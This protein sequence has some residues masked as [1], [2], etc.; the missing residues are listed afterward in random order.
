MPADSDRFYE[1]SQLSMRYTVEADLKLISSLIPAYRQLSQVLHS[2]DPRTQSQGL[3]R[4]LSLFVNLLSVEIDI[5]VAFV[6]TFRGHKS[7]LYMLCLF[8]RA[9][10]G[11]LGEKANASFTV[12]MWWISYSLSMTANLLSFARRLLTPLLTLLQS[13]LPHSRSC[14][15]FGTW[16]GTSCT[17]GRLCDPCSNKTFYLNCVWN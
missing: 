2:H 4:H 16:T 12:R 5:K 11:K 17:N 1:F 8:A 14:L 3:P 7:H 13:V 10:G 6:A 15:L 9:L